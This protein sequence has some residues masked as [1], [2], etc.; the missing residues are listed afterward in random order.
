MK[1]PILLI[2]F[3]GVFNIIVLFC[4]SPGSA[5]EMEAPKCRHTALVCALLAHEANYRVIIACGKNP[6]GNGHCQAA[7]TKRGIDWKP[8]K[9]EGGECRFSFW[10]NF[11]RTRH[12]TLDEFFLRW[13]SKQ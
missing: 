2:F 1:I 7:A 8:L 13:S 11:E 4:C 5:L 10:D 3:Y 6:K 9:Y 12:Y